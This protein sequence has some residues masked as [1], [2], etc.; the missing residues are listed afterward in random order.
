MD[1]LLAIS[2]F[3]Q[4]DISLSVCLSLCLSFSLTFFSFYCTVVKHFYFQL[5]NQS[6]MG[7]HRGLVVILVDYVAR[8]Q[9]FKPQQ[10]QDF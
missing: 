1:F 2:I 9:R 8:G 6:I 5:N 10:K 4:Y 7:G 3:I